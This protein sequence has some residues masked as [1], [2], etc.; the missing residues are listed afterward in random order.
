VGMQQADQCNHYA[1]GIIFSL[2]TLQ[3]YKYWLDVDCTFEN[4]LKII[5]IYV[6]SLNFKGI[7]K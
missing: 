6:N 2:N 4:E 7:V 3:H 5:S 1:G